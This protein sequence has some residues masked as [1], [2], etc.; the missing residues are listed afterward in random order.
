M[1]TR[2]AFTTMTASTLVA[3]AATGR[4]RAQQ[5]SDITLR[6]A[7]Y[8]GAFTAAQRR[9][10][11]DVFTETTGIKIEYVDGS[12][13][14][15]IAKLIASRGREPPYD[16]MYMVKDD[17]DAALSLHMLAKL[18]PSIVTNI[19]Y[20]YPE[21][22]NPDGYGPGL[23]FYSVGI[24]YNTEKF[25]AA[26]I[27]APTS[28]RDLWDPRLAGRVAVANP[29]LSY[30]REFLIAVTRM[31][32]GDESTPEKGI[33]YISQIKAYSYFTASAPLAAAFTSGDVWAAAWINAQAW[34]LIDMGV[35][36]RYVIPK[37]GGIG[38]LDVI[39]MVASTTHPKEAQ[40][41]INMALGPLAE[42]GNATDNPLGPTNTLLEPILQAYPQMAQ[43][44]P[45]SAADL[46]KLYLP[47]WLKYLPHRAEVVDYWN[48]KM[49][50]R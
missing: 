44:F 9:Y 2:R 1:P 3:L 38:N 12:T 47:D 36:L 45:A 13:P 7:S 18:D 19:K 24:A 16:V 40:L 11:G 14:D 21:A 31:L 32:G 43:R 22:R 5:R 6:V 29:S 8:G 49:T 48:R 33:D 37:E 27:P 20:L 35:P 25:K 4:A 39:D 41:Y 30:G 50:G 34:R 23:A 42:L 10:V 46:Q 26:G 17:R 15:Q 28:W